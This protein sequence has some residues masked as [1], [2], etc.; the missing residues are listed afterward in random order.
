MGP[1]NFPRRK[2]RPRAAARDVILIQSGS[3][4]VRIYSTERTAGS[5]YTVAWTCGGRR[6]RQ[7]CRTLEEARKFAKAQ[8]ER[9]AAGTAQSA[10][11][12]LVEAQELREAQRHLNGLDMPLHSATRE[13]ASLLRDLGHHG[14]LRQAVEFFR[15]NAVRPELQRTATQIYEEFLVA[16]K[17]GG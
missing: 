14:T 3:V 10:R 5:Y 2:R 13:Y 4:T 11:I 8:A 7:Y 16:K 12:S 9:I 17:A 15:L 6:Q 1:R